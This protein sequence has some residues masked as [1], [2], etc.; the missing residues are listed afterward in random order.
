MK[1]PPPGKVI[2]PPPSIVFVGIFCPFLFGVGLA[3]SNESLQQVINDVKLGKGV[4]S[5]EGQDQ[6]TDA[7]VGYLDN[8]NNNTYRAIDNYGNDK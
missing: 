8:N 6:T 7:I 1:G 5:E 2:K 3:G 4:V